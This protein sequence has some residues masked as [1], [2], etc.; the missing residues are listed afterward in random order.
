[1][2]ASSTILIGRV[3]DLFWL[4]VEGKGTFQNSLQVKAAF[5]RMTSAGVRAIVVDLERCPIMDSTFLGT[6]TGAAVQ[7]RDV[8]GSL[9]VLNANPRNLQLMTSL[10][11]DFIFEVDAAGEKWQ[12]QRREVAAH[13]NR[14]EEAQ[15]ATRQD[16]A[17]HV[18]DAH[19]M[20]A[21]LSEDNQCRFQDVIDFLEK[22]VAAEPEPRE[23]G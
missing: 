9:S 22:E 3:G 12:A 13:L 16:Q 20:L 5:E 19:R 6:L 18:L 17:E 4:R 2:P 10:G 21:G 1:M 14:C 23:A 7:L 15:G 8:G 11:L